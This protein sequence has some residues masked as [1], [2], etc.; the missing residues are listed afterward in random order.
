MTDVRLVT[1]PGDSYAKEMLNALDGAE[2]FVLVTAFA[3]SSGL[4]VVEPAITQVLDRGGQGRIIVAVDRQGF[5]TGATFER[6]LA[7][8]NEAGARL[9]L[10]L[11][12]EGAG[13]LHAKALFARKATT[14][15][16]LLGSANLTR[17]ALGQNHELGVLVPA[18]AP[19]VRT[20]F[21]RFVTSLAP[22]SLDGDDARAFLEA[23]GLLARPIRAGTQ[24]IKP[25]EAENNGDLLRMLFER[26]PPQTPL[27][28]TGEEHLAAWI[29]R[30]YLVGRGRRSLDALVLRLPQE[31][32]TKRGYLRPPKKE[33]LGI[34]SHETR[35]MGYGVDLLPTAESA[36]VRRDARRVSLL[37]SKVTLELPCFGR[38]MPESYWD[39]FQEA[40]DVLR[41]AASLEPSRLRDVAAAHRRYLET[42]GLEDELDAIIARLDKHEVIVPGKS[43]P[44][45]ADVLAR[46]RSELSLRTP[47][48]IAACLEF[49]TGRQRWAPFEKT[50]TPYRQLM[51]DIMQ[52][53]FAATYRTGDWPRRFRSFAAR[54]L[55]SRI[56][57]RVVTAG[58]QADGAVAT[59]IL[60]QAASWDS[61]RPMA[62]AIAEF[63]ALVDDRF[64]FPVPDLEELA[65]QQD[66]EG[67]ALVSEEEVDDEL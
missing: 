20:A 56:E 18:L 63:R 13:L 51:G 32:L 23:R 5:N 10:G 30:G 31:A 57:E 55:A 49:R 62:D 33:S 12:L 59:E 3:T 48:V 15:T 40:R 28:V 27:E 53:T 1:S 11:V 39:V 60:D 36:C 16:L 50:E 8:K 52:A 46:F 37:L 2:S 7:L 9:T 26:L 65:L 44:L 24:K 47:D 35:T 34:A 22:R 17:A 41:R 38:W 29:A 67:G 61:E 25:K 19:E 58:R 14:D 54:A 66:V 45:R 43:E 42:G 21:L 4:A 64:E 6:L